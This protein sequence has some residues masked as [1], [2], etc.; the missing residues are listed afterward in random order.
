MVS[1]TSVKVNM[2]YNPESLADRKLLA[3]ELEAMFAK[4][5]FTLID[6][7]GCSEKVFAFATQIPNVS[8][9]A[10]STI[11]GDTVRAL[12]DDA[13]RITVVYKRA[14]DKEMQLF[15]AVRVF[16]TGQIEDIVGRTLD[17]LRGA[18][19]NFR[20]R[21]RDGLSCKRCSAP[22]FDTKAGKLACAATCWI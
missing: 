10:Y 4:A 15:K 6:K 2:Q 9:Y 11:D 3:T 19:T 12:G 21:H 22:L 14:D 8:I 1:S 16:R 17:K 13:I 5:N 20:A 7:Q 18:F